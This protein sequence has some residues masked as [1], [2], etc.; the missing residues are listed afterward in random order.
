MN[1]Y[2]IL[3]LVAVAAF[4]AYHYHLTSTVKTA[5]KELFH[6][7][8][9]TAQANAASGS[10]VAGSAPPVDHGATPP[11]NAGATGSLVGQPVPGGDVPDANG[12]IAIPSIASKFAPGSRFLTVISLPYVPAGSA[13]AFGIAANCSN[14][15][16]SARIGGLATVTALAVVPNP[17]ETVAIGGPKFHLSGQAPG[18]K[19]VVVPNVIVLPDTLTTLDAINAYY[20]HQA[21]YGTNTGTGSGFSPGK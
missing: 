6:A 20:A 7:H 12:A 4:A 17:P 21:D 8:A 13:A 18:E 2:V 3:V 14:S 16:E 15:A 1:F 9:T 5:V 19:R 10:S 11:T